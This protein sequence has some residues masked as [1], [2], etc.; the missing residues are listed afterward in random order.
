MKNNK[1]TIGSDPEVFLKKVIDGVEVY[2]PAIT[3]VSGDKYEPTQIDDEGR[4]ILVDNVMLEF[5]TLP[6]NNIDGFM[7]EHINFLNYLKKEMD[8]KGCKISSSAYAEFHPRFLESESAKLFG[9]EPDYNAYTKTV[10]VAPEATVN[11]RSAA[12]HIHVG[13]D[14]PEMGKSLEL[15]KLLDLVLGV[16]SVV[17]DKDRDRRKMYGKAGAFRFKDFGFEYRVLSNYWIFNNRCLRRIYEGVNKAFSL[18]ENKYKMSPKLEKDVISTINNY[19]ITI[20]KKIIND[21]L[22]T[23]N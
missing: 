15:I 9:C 21:E 8:T 20:A 3:V 23:I 1:F 11:F 14:N 12:G 22:K 10:N 13:Y 4:N 5:N 17:Y 19:D 7:N 2:F 16:P 6:T 18:Y